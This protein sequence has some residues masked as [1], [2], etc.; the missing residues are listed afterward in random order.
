[1][2][3]L[4]TRILNKLSTISSFQGSL[5]KGIDSWQTLKFKLNY[6]QKQIALKTLDRCRS[7]DDYFDFSLQYFS[8]HQVRS[9][10]L[11]LLKHIQS[12]EP[13]TVCEIGTA[14]G[15]TNFLLS[16]APQ[17]VT[18]MLGID[19]FVKN[20]AQLCELSRAGLEHVYL[21]ASSYA[22]ETLDRVK[23]VLA[24]RS[25]DVLFIDGDH[26]YDGVRKDFLGYRQFVREGGQIVFHDVVPDYK[27]RYGKDIGRWAG[28]VPQF[29]QKIKHHYP[30]KEFIED[31]NQDGLGIGVITYLESVRLPDDF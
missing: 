18:F 31:P 29:W 2:P 6:Q 13:K 19:L 27:T 4:G 15:G 1:M 12:I 10:I 8:P 17:S 21:D 16:Q 11:N 3:D 25:L 26:N 30:H 7:L 23:Q 28:E 14:M 22:P 20:K 9:E 5:T 24:G